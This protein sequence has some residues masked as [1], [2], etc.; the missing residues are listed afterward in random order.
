MIISDYPQR[1][2]LG[3]LMV[4]IYFHLREGK[5]FLEPK[6]V[7]RI[8]ASCSERLGLNQ[9]QDP[10]QEEDCSPLK[11]SRTVAMYGNNF[12]SNYLAS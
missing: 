5:V 10:C 9:P 6:L 8:L 4:V 3:S 11:P 12:L 7:P 2:R 1:D